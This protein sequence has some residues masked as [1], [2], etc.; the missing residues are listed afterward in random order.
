VVV[1]SLA[2]FLALHSPEHIGWSGAIR[3]IPFKK[4]GQNQFHTLK[5]WRSMLF[6]PPPIKPRTRGSRDYTILLFLYNT[7]S[8]AD[9]A[10]Q[11]LVGDLNLA[12]RRQDSSHVSLRGKGNKVRLCPLWPQT[13]KQLRTLV[14]NRLLTDRVFLKRYNRPI[15][16]FGIYQMVERYAGKTAQKIPSLAGKRVSPHS[17]RHTTACHLLRS[18]VDINT[19]RAWLGHVS[20]TTTNI[21]AEVDLEMKAKALALCDIGGA[22]QTRQWQNDPGLMNFLRSI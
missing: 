6:W 11:L 8:R 10:A 14:T 22:G 18:G 9:E 20:L 21:Y 7:G 4:T 13:V 3:A 19:I 17:I 15:T 1:R 5:S 16:R 12:A 2:R